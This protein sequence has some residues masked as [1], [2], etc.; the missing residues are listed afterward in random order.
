MSL[1]AR[2]P[3]NLV[4]A[5]LFLSGGTALVYELVWSKYLGNVLGNSG[6]AHA[7]VLAT[8][9]G[10]LALGASV[11]GRTA[12]RVKSPL[13]LYGVLELGVALY[14][15]AFPYVLDALGALWLAVAPGVPDGWRVGPRLLVAAV[16]LVVPTL[17]MGGTLPALVRHFADSLSGVQRELARL[18]AVNSLGAALGVFIA[19]TKLVPVLGLSASAKLAAG[20]NLLL[21]V[22]AL[23]L[24][25]RHPPALAPGQAAPVSE[26][27]A[28]L[29]YPRVAVRAA[30]VGVA[31]S[32]FTSMLYQVTWI[33]LLSIVLGASTYAFTLILTAFILGIGL[34]SFWL[35]TRAQKSDPLKLYGQM[36]VALVASLCVALPLY[37]RLPHLFRSAQWMM[38]RS[39]DTWPL[40]QLLTFG[41]CCLVLLVPTFFMGAAFPAAARVATAKVSEVGR[42]LGGVYLW[43]T[44]GTITG[45]ALGGLV[46]MPWWGMEGNFVA[47]VVANLAA[48][49]LAFHAL[50]GRPSSPVRALWPVGA[51]ALLAAVVLGGMS[52]WSVRLSGIASIRSHQ[53]P[54]ESYAKLVEET[55]KNIHPIFYR[56]DTFATVMVADYPQ[57]HLRFMKL[58]GKIDASNGSDVETQVI[59]GHLG[60]LLH[61]RE[62]KNVLLVGAGAAITAGSVLA[63]P[64]ERLDM[65]E[66]APAVIDAARLFKEDNRNAVDDPR[67]RVHIDDAK[68]FMALAERKYDLVVSVPSNPW[69]AGVSGLFT[70]DFFQTVDRHLADDG[71]LVQ[72]IHTYES[73]DE[74]IRLVVRTL[75]DTFPHATTWLGPHDLVLVAS[76]KP[77]AFDAERLAQR[78]A[79]P[80][81]RADMGRVG[82]TDVFALLS[83]QVHSEDGQ[84]AFAGP[85]P[86][87]TDDHNLLEYAS[88]IAFFVANIDV[89]VKDE[90]RSPEGGSRLF[91]EDYL[92]QHPPTAEEAARLYRNM[93]RYHAANDPLV[94]GVATLWRSVAPDSR[95]ATVALGKAALAQKDLTLA[96]SLLEPEVA[97]GGREPELVAAYLKL[98]AE[99]AWATRTVWTPVDA[100]PALALGRQVASE[101]PADA[102]LARAVRNLCD[103]LPASACA[104]SKTPVAAPVGP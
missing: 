67:T 48:A 90:R 2:F 82:L 44:V 84:L 47:G 26:S 94:R 3:K 49:A 77:L 36:Q 5:L 4:S 15:L 95:E 75:R 46:L 101:F 97:K 50:P 27:T 42:E 89:R 23:L 64:V 37:V 66:I 76:R 55:E 34:G 19:G 9:M 41:F 45:S 98:V 16:S 100:A 54:P 35:M 79:V 74:L 28:N 43:N 68:T 39:V 8:F 92:R 102:E 59:A 7:V 18:Y 96:A 14:A 73:N 93:E 57:D 99:R 24:A 88:P 69:V 70:R 6:Q 25:R 20:L 63:H 56:D 30:L 17:L 40:F 78:M 62:P 81:V 61:P 12:D 33:R 85:G 13:A 22:A 72:W 11:F 103:A 53:K 29:A 58:N 65:V 83:K 31:L 52:G 80:E 10:G 86:I 38:T 91:L 104:P 21:A 32:G 1:I 71:V 60:A 87:N 51:V